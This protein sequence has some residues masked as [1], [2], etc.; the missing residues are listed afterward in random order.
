MCHHANIHK[1]MQKNRLPSLRAT[2]LAD[3]LVCFLCGGVLVGWPLPLSALF[4]GTD[5]T[6]AGASFAVFLRWLGAVVILI[7]AGVYATAKAKVMSRRAVLAIVLVE[8][9]WLLGSFLLLTYYR[10]SLTPGGIAFVAGGGLVVFVFMV[11]ELIGLQRFAAVGA[12][13]RSLPQS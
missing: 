12:P 8:V 9:L 4:A 6:I 2:L 5:L 3:S 1:S 11:L 13:Q 7:G 10:Q